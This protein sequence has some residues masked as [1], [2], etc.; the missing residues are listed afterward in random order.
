MFEDML[1][2]V[3]LPVVRRDATCML[4]AS[5]FWLNKLE[6]PA[7]KHPLAPAPKRFLVPGH[8]MREVAQTIAD[9]ELFRW[10][11]G[12]SAWPRPQYAGL[13]VVGRDPPYQ[14]RCDL[15]TARQAAELLER[16]IAP[17]SGEP[18]RVLRNV[19]GA[20]RTADEWHEQAAPKPGGSVSCKGGVF[21]AYVV[22]NPVSM[23]MA[24]ETT[25]AVYGV[26]ATEPQ[27]AALRERD[28]LFLHQ[29]T[30]HLFR[31]PNKGPTRVDWTGYADG[32]AQVWLS[33]WDG[34]RFVPRDIRDAHK[35]RT[36]SIQ[37]RRHITEESIYVIVNCT[38]GSVF[39]DSLE[40]SV[41]Q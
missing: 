19:V 36:Y 6:E 17:L 18:K 32:N 1:L 2:V 33:Y 16:A 3:E 9:A 29:G 24:P 5:P 27:L 11:T 28:D 10:E 4:T 31:I 13:A 40:Y 25:I 12:G 23:T 39:T 34:E 37:V 35:S 8:E 22:P 15:G 30:Y 7:P 26:P 41:V 38:N 21:H 14:Y 20:L